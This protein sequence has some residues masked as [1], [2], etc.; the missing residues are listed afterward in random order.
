[1]FSELKGTRQNVMVHTLGEIIDA[2]VRTVCLYI[3][4]DQGTTLHQF[5]AQANALIVCFMLV[6]SLRV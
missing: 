3:R 5:V 4:M 6:D 1:M 2:Y